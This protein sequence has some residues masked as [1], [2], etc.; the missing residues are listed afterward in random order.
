MKLT[1]VNV[2]YGEAIVAECPDEKCRDGRFVMVID[3]G[4]GEAGE[5]ADRASGRQT[6]LEYLES[7][8]IRQI[9]CMEAK[10]LVLTCR[11]GIRI[12]LE[13]TN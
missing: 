12:I 3:G 7:T 13:S 9:D 8:D 5:Y 4:S 10:G 1:F 11:T 2:G 6:L